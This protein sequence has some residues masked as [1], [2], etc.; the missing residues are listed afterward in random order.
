MVMSMYTLL[1]NNL[2]PTELEMEEAL[3]GKRYK[4]IITVLSFNFY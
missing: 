2:Q 3:H 4:G 1:R